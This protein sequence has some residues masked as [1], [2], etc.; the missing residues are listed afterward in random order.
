MKPIDW[1]LIGVSAAVI[2]G[3]II[4]LVKRKKAGKGGCG[5]GCANCPSAGKCG[6]TEEEDA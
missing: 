1:I 5:C 3:V 2:I 6:K 4:H